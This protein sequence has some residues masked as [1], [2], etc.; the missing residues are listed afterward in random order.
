M[1]DICCNLF[2][3]CWMKVWKTNWYLKCEKE[4]DMNNVDFNLVKSIQKQGRKW[5]DRNNLYWKFDFTP[6]LNNLPSACQ[7]LAKYRRRLRPRQPVVATSLRQLWASHVSEKKTTHELTSFPPQ[8]IPQSKTLSFL[9]ML[10]CFISFVPFLVHFHESQTLSTL[11]RKKYFFFSSTS[12]SYSS[13]SFF[14]V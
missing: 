5:F 14:S 1:F 2:L 11:C 12:F 7:G 9:V 10:V 4:I 13:T 8:T 6:R 3:V